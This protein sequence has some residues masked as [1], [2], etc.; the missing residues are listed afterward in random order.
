MFA[1][2]IVIARVSLMPTSIRLLTVQALLPKVLASWDPAIFSMSMIQFEC[3]TI[4]NCECPLTN[5]SWFVYMSDNKVSHGGSH[6]SYPKGSRLCACLGRQ[7]LKKSE[8][9]SIFRQIV[10]T[11]EHITAPWARRL[12]VSNPVHL[13]QMNCQLSSAIPQCKCTCSATQK[14]LKLKLNTAKFYHW[15]CWH[16]SSL[17]TWPQAPETL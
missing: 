10:C 1:G 16:Q 17:H 13:L 3:T 2:L 15:H 9:S 6:F 11:D 12:I 7:F 14:N 8:K 5:W 4:I